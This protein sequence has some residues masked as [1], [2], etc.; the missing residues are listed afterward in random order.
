MSTVPTPGTPAP[1]NNAKTTLLSS[2]PSLYAR[3]TAGYNASGDAAVASGVTPGYSIN[4]S[5][6]A[7][8]TGG[9]QVGSDFQGATQIVAQ[10]DATGH[11]SSETG[12]G[13]VGDS[14]PGL[15]Q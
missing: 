1:A 15:G 14:G 13:T 8:S 12:G 3:P 9:T 2:D 7:P 6:A 5:G 4:P 10:P 11:P